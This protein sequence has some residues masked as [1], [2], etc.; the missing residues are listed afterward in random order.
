MVPAS[1][2]L[3]LTMAAALVCAGNPVVAIVLSRPGQHVDSVS[4]MDHSLC[5]FCRC[6]G[7][8]P[9]MMAGSG[10]MKDGNMRLLSLLAEKRRGGP[11]GSWPCCAVY[12]KRVPAKVHREVSF[13]RPKFFMVKVTAPTVGPSQYRSAV[14]CSPSQPG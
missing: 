13:V 5:R 11:P 7:S 3:I 9:S 1:N 4:L 14:V 6:T 12:R 2:P 8:L 10:M